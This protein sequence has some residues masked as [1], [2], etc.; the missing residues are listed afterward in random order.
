VLYSLKVKGLRIQYFLTDL[1]VY[2]ITSLLLA[3]LKFSGDSS[4]INIKAY[5]ITIIVLGILY[6][7]FLYMGGNYEPNIILDLKWSI[8]L[9][10]IIYTA[11][12][13]FVASFYIRSVS[14]SRVYFTTLFMANLL[15]AIIRHLSLNKFHLKMYCD[16]LRYPM[17]A[18]GFEKSEPGMLTKTADVLG[19]KV[20]AELDSKGAISYLSSLKERLI[21][22]RDTGNKDDIGILLYEEGNGEFQELISF[23]EINYIPLFILPSAARM[24]SVPLKAYEHKGLLVFGPKDLLVDGVS[25]RLKRTVDVVL[26]TIG[27]VLTSWLMLLIWVIVKVSSI[28]PGLFAQERL[29]IDGKIIRIYK[30]RTMFEDSEKK[31]NDL[32]EDDKIRRSYYKD[33]K[34]ENDPR[35]TKVGHYLRKLSL[36]ELPQLWNIFRGDISFVGPRPIIPQELARYGTHGKMILRVKPGLTGLWQVNGRN[37]VSYEER[38][39]LDLYYIHNWSLGLDFKIIIQTVPSVILGKGAC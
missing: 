37:D 32:L 19:L 10:A 25:K 29:G 24:L 28:G 39:N 20:I 14:Y 36:D 23:C 27:V 31:L 8:Y 12:V 26:A 16:E 5:F 30:F 18:V 9:R 2:L 38:I 4:V 35:I 3:L 15:I 21:L 22:A 6:L 1:L 13:F 17:V 33:Y 11:A 34:L 7:G